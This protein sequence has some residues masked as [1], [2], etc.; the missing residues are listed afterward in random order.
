MST[1]KISQLPVQTGFNSNT[2]NTVLV[3][4]DL[5]N[6]ITSQITLQT[7]LNR[8]FENVTSISF[9][10]SSVQLSAPATIQ[11][12]QASFLQANTNSN[13]IN[14]LQGALNT[15]NSG[16][17]SNKANIASVLNFT[18]NAY[19][20]ANTNATIINYLGGALNTANANT[21]YLQ[22]ALNTANSNTI[23]LSGVVNS[24]NSN[25][26]ALQTYSQA[27]FAK[28]NAALSNTSG[29]IFSGNLVVSGTLNS[30]KGF[31]YT[32]NVVNNQANT[33]TIDFTRDSLIVQNSSG[34]LTVTLSNFVP[35]KEVILWFTNNSGSTQ[36]VNHGALANNSTVNSTAFSIPSTSTAYL[37]YF[38]INN[39]LSNT[40]VAITHA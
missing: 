2:S 25:V 1:V 17:S 33:L 12:S 11:Y 29:T 3:T 34:G 24:T 40:F 37:R 16:I 38:S 21:V 7:L 30:Q 31:I 39:S 35:G 13:N 9:A 5:A 6:S 15:A 20:E 8:T 36:T 27:G 26:I 32:P 4:V 23:Y 18:Q 19:N 22:G 28:A 14:Y 10:D